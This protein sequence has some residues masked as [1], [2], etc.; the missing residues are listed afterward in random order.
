MLGPPCFGKLAYRLEHSLKTWL[1]VQGIGCR[2]TGLGYR[3]YN[4]GFSVEVLGSMV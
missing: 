3:V 2:A 1:R 4:I